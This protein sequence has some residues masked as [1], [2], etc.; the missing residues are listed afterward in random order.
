MSRISLAT[1]R[2]AGRTRSRATRGGFTLVELLVVMGIIALLIGLL[3]PALAKAR[4]SALRTKCLSNLHGATVGLMAYL[5]DNN[6]YLPYVLPLSEDQ[7][8]DEEEEDLL[9]T[10]DDYISNFDV[11][12]CP[13]DDTGVGE[14]L[15]S[16]YEYWPGWIMFAR[17][18]FRG[19]SKRTV[20]RTVTVFYE[21]TPGKWP[22]LADAEAW[23]GASGADTG[24]N[25]SFWDGS[26]DRLE[27]W[28]DP[29]WAE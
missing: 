8:D 23:H 29:K 11:F 4:A 14:A 6:N 18:F 21:K 19:E 12:L 26:A 9:T 1:G 22:V 5:P 20:A 24:K 17:E 2:V 3:S 13:S 27:N 15:G 10:L 7:Y 16:S 28:Q 25:A